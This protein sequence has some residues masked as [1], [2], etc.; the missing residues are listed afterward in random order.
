MVPVVVAL[1]SNVGDS[2]THL[3]HAERSLAGEE[4]RARERDEPG[5]AAAR[6]S[7]LLLETLAARLTGSPGRAEQAADTAER[8]R[9]QVPAH[10]LDRHPELTALLLAHL[11]STR[12]WAGHL[13]EARAAL[14]L[15]AEGSDGVSTALPREDSLGRLALI[16]YLNGVELF[17]TDAWA[18]ADAEFGM[19]I[20][21][22]TTK[23]WHAMFARQLFRRKR[24]PHRETT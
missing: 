9:E 11:G 14:S 1:G 21:V 18:G 17:V 22:V 2:L 13:E 12:L 19:P 20:R 3:R 15:V 10:L 5:P 24:R 23:A 4:D 6:L 7:C 16:D 8:L